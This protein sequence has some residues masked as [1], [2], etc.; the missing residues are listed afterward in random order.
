[1]FWIQGRAVPLVQ[2]LKLSGWKV[3]AC[4]FRHPISQSFRFQRNKCIFEREFLLDQCSRYKYVHK[5]TKPHSFIHWPQ[6][7]MWKTWGRKAAPSVCHVCL[8]ACHTWHY[9]VSNDQSEASHFYRLDRELPNK[10][11]LGNF[12]AG[13]L[14]FRSG[15]INPHSSTVPTVQCDWNNGVG[16]VHST[17]TSTVISSQ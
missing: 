16:S 10:E 13:L 2:W 4:G 3:W 9:T 8:T 15:A 5:L 17:M 12:I 11:Y 6:G 1:M 7:D 14:F